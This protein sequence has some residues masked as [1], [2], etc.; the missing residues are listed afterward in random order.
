MDNLTLYISDMHCSS[1]AMRIEGIE[2]ELP[3]IRQISA[4]Y[5]QGTVKVEYDPQQVSEREICTAIEKLGYH[6]ESP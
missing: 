6:F 3:G 4:S 2:D 1:C 5:R